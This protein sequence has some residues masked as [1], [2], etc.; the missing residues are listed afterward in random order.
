[1][2][3]DQGPTNEREQAP[4]PAPLRPRWHPMVTAL[5]ILVGLPLL[6]PGVCG[7]LF[8]HSGA[9]NPL[10]AMGFVISFGG[11][12][13]IVFGIRRLVT[14]APSNPPAVNETVKLTI[15]V[16]L[17]FIFLV[18]AILVANMLFPQLRN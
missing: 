4:S 3:S 1:M 15:L 6:L 2:S 18:T 8:T 12:A 11:L 5:M 9:G 7:Y 14:S 13:M 10:A 17:F 16:V